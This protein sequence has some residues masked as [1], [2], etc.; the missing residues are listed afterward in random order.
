[1]PTDVNT[2]IHRYLKALYRDTNADVETLAI[3][4]LK[5]GA[6]GKRTLTQL[7]NFTQYDVS[8]VSGLVYWLACD[9]NLFF[10][11]VGGT[12]AVVNNGDSIAAWTDSVNG[13]LATEATNPPTYTTDVLHGFPSAR[14]DGSNDLLSVAAAGVAM[15]RN[16]PGVTAICAFVPN[17]IGAAAN[18]MLWSVQISGTSMYNFQHNL[19]NAASA[20]G[21]VRALAADGGTTQTSS[22]NAHVEDAAAVQTMWM[23]YT[24]KSLETFVNGTSVVGPTTTNTTAGNMAD[25][26]ASAIR[27]GRQAN[28]AAAFFDGDMFELMVFNVALSTASRQLVERYLGT[29]YGIT[30][31]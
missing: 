4:W 25:S 23:D 26:D 16:V 20:G 31:V 28:S 7:G 13:W 3:R 17:N 12:T 29:K 22:A 30:V 9:A 11:N 27:V 19:T 14:F 18:R 21:F 15:V 5:S 8:T 6:P 1:M 2:S 24:N 10:T